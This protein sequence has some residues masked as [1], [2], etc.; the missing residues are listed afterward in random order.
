LHS[1]T[2]TREYAYGPAPRLRASYAGV[3]ELC[4]QP[5]TGI[6]S[7]PFA[8]IERKVGLSDK[9]KQ[10]L[11]KVRD[12]ARKAITPSMRRATTTPM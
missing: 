9:Q 11:G 12:A 5:G 1:C 3:E 10:L 2:S 4:Q 8:E 7:W 6:T